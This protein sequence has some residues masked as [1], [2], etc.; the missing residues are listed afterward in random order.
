MTKSDWE[1]QNKSNNSNK[2]KTKRNNASPYSFP[3]INSAK[4]SNN[5][6]LAGIMSPKQ[7]KPIF[8]F[9]KDKDGRYTFRKKPY[10]YGKYLTS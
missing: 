5:D 3:K 10:I 7:D 1:S 8:P 2:F 9:I 4:D 6:D